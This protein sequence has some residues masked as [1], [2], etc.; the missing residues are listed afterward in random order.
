MP[1]CQVMTQTHQMCAAGGSMQETQPRRT[2]NKTSRSKRGAGAAAAAQEE[3][4]KPAQGKIAP[5]SG[6]ENT[7]ISLK[8]ASMLLASGASPWQGWQLSGAAFRRICSMHR[9]LWW[10]EE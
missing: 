9:W 7:L 3:K 2:R 1:P 4:A 6:E 8:T 5:A 10:Q